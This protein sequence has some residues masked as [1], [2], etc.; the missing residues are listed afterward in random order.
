MDHLRELAEIALQQ[1]RTFHRYDKEQAEQGYEAAVMRWNRVIEM[2]S[3][4]MDA[5]LNCSNALLNLAVTQPQEQHYLRAREVLEPLTKT[6][7]VHRRV[8]AELA[9]CLDDYGHWLEN[10]DRHAEATEL[11][12]KAL[13]LRKE[14]VSETPHDMEALR[15]LARSYDRVAP[16][17]FDFVPVEEL[18]AFWR[19]YV[20]TMEMDLTSRPAE[21]ISADAANSCAWNMVICPFPEFRNTEKAIAW[22]QIAV[23]Q[24]PKDGGMLNTLAAAYY[25][26][27]EWNK[28]HELLQQA[29]QLRNGGD[30]YDWLLL[31][32]T[33][34]RLGDGTA[35]RQWLRKSSE[36]IADRNPKSAPLLRLKAEAEALIP[37][38]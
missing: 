5:R 37:A 34:S 26:N 7:S 9:L 3:E 10:H 4:G 23:K 38:T 12:G 21:S 32:M 2:D 17:V 24:R 31:A 20:K 22:G 25:R 8:R 16:P 29:A 36:Y 1:G 14:L 35:A 33:S 15:L 6:R 28:A 18:K 30:V 19:M 11:L 13:Q 27:G